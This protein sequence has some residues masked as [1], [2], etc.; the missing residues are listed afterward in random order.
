MEVITLS[1]EQKAVNFDTYQHID[2]VRKYL[3]DVVIQ[4]LAQNVCA[5]NSIAVDDSVRS[6]NGDIG[7]MNLVDLV[8]FL[9][10]WRAEPIPFNAVERSFRKIVEARFGKYGIDPQLANILANSA[11]VF[12]EQLSG[13]AVTFSDIARAFLYDVVFAL[14]RRG[15]EHDRTK[16]FEPEVDLFVKYTPELAKCHYGSPEYDE[17]LKGLKPALDHHYGNNRHHPEHFKAGIGDMNIID[18]VEMMCDWKAATLRQ[19]DGN[20]RKSVE[21]NAARFQINKQL[22]RIL[23]NS[24]DLFDK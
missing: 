10:S 16:L 7:A 2:K 9:V 13:G 17:A 1:T 19:K 3:N 11:S 4:L 18:I 14:L 22:V 6:F 5:S 20:L 15:S 21:L 23:E 24:M 8:R 12:G